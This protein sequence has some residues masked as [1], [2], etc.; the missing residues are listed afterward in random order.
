MAQQKKKYVGP[1]RPPRDPIRRGV[2]NTNEDR[3]QNLSD[4]DKIIQFLV[5]RYGQ[6]NPDTGQTEP[7]GLS[8][9]DLTKILE[10]ILSG[11]NRGDIPSSGQEDAGPFQFISPPGQQQSL[12]SR[13]LNFP[14]LTPRSSPSQD[15]RE[16]ILS[17]L[18]GGGALSRPTRYHMEYY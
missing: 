8:D 9:Q 3:D 16:R 17:M 11:G 5:A 7:E 2:P 18:M 12:P 4:I 15:S 14:A 1:L 10:E 13:Q 6:T